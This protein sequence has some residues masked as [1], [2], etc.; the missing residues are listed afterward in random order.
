MELSS[1]QKKFRRDDK[2][3]YDISSTEKADDSSIFDHHHEQTNPYLCVQ[4]TTPRTKGISNNNNSGYNTP[5]TTISPVSLAL[6]NF[7]KE[8]RDAGELVNSFDGPYSKVIVWMMFPR[9]RLHV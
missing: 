4:S 7:W 8:I 9:D 2:R 1:C 3:N 5:T 6:H